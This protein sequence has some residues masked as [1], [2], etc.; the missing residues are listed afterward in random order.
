[1]ARFLLIAI[2]IFL[3]LNIIAIAALLRIHPR[4]R[5]LV[6]AV[7]A[8]CNVMWLFLPLLN[9]RTDFSRAVRAI[10]GPPWFAWLCFILIY[11]AVLFLIGVVWIPFRAKSFPQFAH[12]PSR[13]FLWTTL[14]ALPVGIYTAL[15]PLDVERVPVVLDQL[16]PTLNGIRIAVIADLHVGLFTRPSRLRKIFATAASLSPDVVVLAGDMVDDDPF[17]TTKLLEGTGVL[18][19]S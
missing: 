3:V 9:A 18:P 12:W 14:I 1:M 2:A 19:S 15:V 17:F 8:I 10:L 6:I 5:P 11:C 7:A 4:R 13:I 16:P